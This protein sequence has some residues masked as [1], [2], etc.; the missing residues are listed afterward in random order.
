MHL[1]YIPRAAFSLSPQS[2]LSFVPSLP[3]PI[4]LSLL[5]KGRLSWLSTH[6]S[7]SSCSRIRYIFC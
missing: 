1:L 3:I 7:I 2:F 5:R 6:P 4:S